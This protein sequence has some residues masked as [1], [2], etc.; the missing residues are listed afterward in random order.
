VHG[1]A[2][3]RR[4]EAQ[5]ERAGGRVEGGEE[6]EVAELADALRGEAGEG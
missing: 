3:L 6:E 1:A 2:E 5:R 4:E